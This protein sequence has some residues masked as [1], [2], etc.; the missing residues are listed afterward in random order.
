M[1][2]NRNVAKGYLNHFIPEAFDYLTKKKKIE[3]NNQTLKTDYLLNII[4]ELIMRYFIY[5]NDTIDKEIKFPLS[6]VL[7]KKKYGQLYNY[8]IEYLREHQFLILASDYYVG[9]HSRIYKL[10]RDLLLYIKWVKV[11]DK[12]LLK[13]N[14]KDF[15]KSTFLDYNKSPI[16]MEIRKKLVNDLYDI[17]IDADS[18]LNYL[19]QLKKDNNI[20]YDKYMKN[21]MMVENLKSDNL[22]FKFDEYGRMHTNFTV[23]K[24]HIRKNYLTIDGERL[25]EIDISNSQPLFLAVLMKQELSVNELIKPEFTRYINLVKNGLIYEELMNK[26]DVKDREEAKYMMFVVLFGKNGETRKYNKMFNSVFPD[27]FK[28]IRK[29][30]SDKNSHKELS[31]IL[32]NLESKFIFDKVVNHIMEVHPEIKFFTVHD[33]IVVPLKYKENAQKI[34]DYHK[35]NLLI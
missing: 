18:A 11:N 25:E 26:C 9:Q 27:V 6:S 14:S 1:I 23:L 35:R 28:F 31:Y 17:K 12:I 16:P 7:L 30:K 5:K 13:K 20:S 33:S 8:Y 19:K 10:N 4:H 24:K 3:Y 21:T 29:Y 22:F 15:L 2:Y 32:Q 34:F